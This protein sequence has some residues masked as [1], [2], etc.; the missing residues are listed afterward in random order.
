MFCID[1]EYIPFGA[2]YAPQDPRQPFLFLLLSR[3]GYFRISG[4]KGL[5]YV[6]SFVRFNRAHEVIDGR[7]AAISISLI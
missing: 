4:S 7:G 6:E 2:V 3:G 5:G 1:G